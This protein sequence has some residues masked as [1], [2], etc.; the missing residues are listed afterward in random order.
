MAYG[1]D[2]QDFDTRLRK[3]LVRASPCERLQRLDDE[4][5]LGHELHVVLGVMGV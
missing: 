3:A 5:V 4:K 2:S 1:G